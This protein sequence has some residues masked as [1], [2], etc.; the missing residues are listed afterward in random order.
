LSLPDRIAA[1]R[2]EYDHCFGC[3]ERNPIG[4][5]LNGF[6]R[7]DTRVTA[8]FTPRLD[9]HGFSDLLHGGIVAAALD[10][11]MAWTAI[12]AAE[13][14]VMTGTLDL[15]YRKPAK[16]DATFTLEGELVE[17]RGRRLQLQGRMTDQQ[18][19]VAEASGLFLAIEDLGK[20][21]NRR[22]ASANP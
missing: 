20:L 22:D 17:R 16:V 4:L 10:E 18:I 5:R 19:V 6:S 12:L 14:M 1:V 2:A 8:L 15:R 9:Y 11:I 13:V 7:A 21:P 3:G